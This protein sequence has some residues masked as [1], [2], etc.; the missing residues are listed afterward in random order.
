MNWS[1][2]STAAEA[3]MSTEIHFLCEQVTSRVGLDLDYRLE[4]EGVFW[5][6]I[7]QP[8]TP[9]NKDTAALDW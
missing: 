3:E 6:V 5:Y 9:R 8:K 1:L 7:K 4:Y 2:A